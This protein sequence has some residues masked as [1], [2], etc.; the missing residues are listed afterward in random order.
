MRD[1]QCKQT[2]TGHESDI[3][4]VTVRNP[5]CF[6]LFLKTTSNYSLGTVYFSCKSKCFGSGSGSAPG[7]GSISDEIDR[8][9]F[10]PHVRLATTFH[11]FFSYP[12]CVSEPFVYL[13]L[14]LLL[15]VKIKTF[16][17]IQNLDLDFSYSIFPFSFAIPCDC[18]D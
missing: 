4:A 11:K 15:F 3:N 6:L 7:S 2:F 17:E 12:E 9:Y 1:G 8:F 16:S 14:I 13:R 18:C 5:L 10:F